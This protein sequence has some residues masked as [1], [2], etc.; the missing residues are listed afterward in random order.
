M[1]NS[2]LDEHWSRGFCPIINGIVFSSGKIDWVNIELRSTPGSTQFHLTPGTSTSLEDLEKEDDLE[3]TTVITLS[4]CQSQRLNLKVI[5]GEGGLGSD[6]FV[7]VSEFSSKDLL[8]IAFFECSNPFIKIHLQNGVV[9][10]ETTLGNS[11]VFPVFS[12]EKVTVK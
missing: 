5:C 10:A 8:W 7:A 2:I 9:T 4:E 1:M 12:P 6:G 11:W 3:W